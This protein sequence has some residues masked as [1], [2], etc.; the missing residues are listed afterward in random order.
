[1]NKRQVLSLSAQCLAMP[2]LLG[3]SGKLWAAPAQLKVRKNLMSLADTDPFFQQY[4]DAVKAMHAL[5]TTDLRSWWGQATIHADYC[6]HGTLNFVSWHRPY[7]ALFES[8]CAK[9]T[10][11][12]A[13]TL[14]YWDWSQK[15]GIIPDPF[16]DRQELDVTYWK[17]PGVYDGKN[18]GH[19]DTRPIRALAKGVG[20]QSDPIRGGVF[21]SKELDTIRHQTVFDDFTNMLENQPHNSA[22]VIVGFPASGRPGH[23][24]AGLSPL[25]PIFWM[26][27]TMVDYL[28]AQW[29]H[30]G[31]QTHDH[32]ETWAGM[33][34][35]AEGNPVTYTNKQVRDTS[36]LGYTYDTM[37]ATNA[38]QLL[39]AAPVSSAFQRKLALQLAASKPRSLASSATTVRVDAGT[40]TR[41]PVRVQSLLQELQ[42]TRVFRTRLGDQL[43]LATEGRRVLAI[44]KQ[45]GWPEGE[46]QGLMVNVFVNCPYLTPSTSS[47]DPHYAGTFSFFGSANMHHG[48][49]HGHSIVVD[50]TAPLLAQAAQ[51]R[52]DETILLQ[53]V[54]IHP[55]SQGDAKASFT[56][57]DVEIISE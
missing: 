46:Q 18:W 51:G 11:D 49:H 40:P 30:A 1:M 2:A 4:G 29:Q 54:S 39:A 52:L 48:G 21:T 47:E 7:L 13:F 34:V 12:A 53:L 20:L 27:H 14:H 24:G 8:I 55:Q 35:D 26:H 16:Y 41:L 43:R 32:D 5:S 50:I 42:G 56:V 28:W 33:F 36:D 23:M 9:L 17:D 45:V 31:N 19:I 37:I 22:H 38:L 44:L 25:D 6:Q 10:G 3:T 15:N 57:K